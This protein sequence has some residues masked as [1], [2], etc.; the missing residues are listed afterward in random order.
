MTEAAIFSIVIAV[1]IFVVVCWLIS[2]LP[3]PA[4]APPIKWV[5]YVLAGVIFIL[6]LLRYV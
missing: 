2:I 3:L 6:Y 1:L 5:L 4:N